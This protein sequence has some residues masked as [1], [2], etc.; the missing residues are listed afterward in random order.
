M[1]RLLALALALA[2]L[3]PGPL[4]AAGP[5]AAPP[6]FV[7][8]AG[9]TVAAADVH[10]STVAGTAFAWIDGVDLSPYYGARI[11]FTDTAGRSA[12]AYIKAAGTG[13]TLGANAFLTPDFSADIDWDKGSGWTIGAGVATHTAGI[14]GG[15]LSQSVATIGRLYKISVTVSGWTAGDINTYTP[16]VIAIPP[17]GDGAKSAYRTQTS[18][19]AI[20][21]YAGSSAAY[22]LDDAI[23]EHVLTPPVTGVTL[24][25][26]KAGTTYNFR[27]ISTG[28]D[29]NAVTRYR[30]ERD[31][32]PALVHSGTA[33]AGL[34]RLSLVDGTAFADP[35]I[36]EDWSNFQVEPHL[37][38]LQDPTGKTVGGF[39]LAGGTGETL[40]AELI[41]ANPDNRTFASDTGYW[42]KGAGVTIS[43]GTANWLSGA[44]LF[45]AN[46]TISGALYRTTYTLSAYVSGGFGVWLGDGITYGV[47]HTSD[48]AKTDYTTSTGA[49]TTAYYGFIAPGPL[50]VSMDN[51]SLAQV[52]TPSA[53]G[54]TIRNT[55]AGAVQNWLWKD[56]GFNPN[57]ALA[58]RFY[59]LGY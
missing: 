26:A 23:L 29:P 30:V 59:Y 7:V 2:L 44:Y 31:L 37:L 38:V 40:G 6:S 18:G 33:G 3:A 52:L 50:T 5:A 47:R 42:A 54:V 27:S 15:A 25:S 11:T 22:N 17:A 32:T 4:S 12:V 48:G 28:F 35:N 21:F 41:N 19:T 13:E 1:R 49:G 51:V 14:G 34:A 57:A 56:T 53:T 55:R 46:L 43:A 36:G 39:V 8:L 9:G 10:L 20:G 45:R 16:S 24:V 58:F